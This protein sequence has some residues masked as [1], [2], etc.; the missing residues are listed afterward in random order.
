ML[1]GIVPAQ[2]A[3]TIGPGPARGTDRA[4]VTWYEDFQDWS[5]AD[6]KALDGAGL[7]DARYN[8]GDGRDDS[9]D[10][11]AFYFRDEGGNLYFRVDLYDLALGAENGSLA[12]LSLIHI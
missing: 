6:L 3:L 4:G 12:I 9:R 8:F 10:L 11:V 5:R 7:A 2:A 1:T